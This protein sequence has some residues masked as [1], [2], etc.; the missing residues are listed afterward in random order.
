MK[1]HALKAT[2]MG[3]D[4][5]F[6]S[7]H[8]IPLPVPGARVLRTAFQGGDYIHHSRYSLIFNQDRGFATC[9]AHNIEGD[10]LSRK[11]YKSRSFKFDPL[12]KPNRLQVDKD[13]GYRNNPWDQGHI[14][15]RKSMSWGDPVDAA[16]AERESDHW[17]NIAPQH[18]TLHSNA[19][20]LIEDWMLKRVEGGKH[21]ACVFG[22]PVFTEDD[23]ILQNAPDETPIQIPAGFWKIISIELDGAMRSAAFLLWQRDYDHAEPLPFAPVLEQVRLSTIEVLTGLGFPALRTFD[24]L[25]YDRD[26]N[27]KVA[28]K[29]TKPP[30]RVTLAWD[31]F[32]GITGSNKSDYKSLEQYKSALPAAT[33]ISDEN[34]ILL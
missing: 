31:E 8:T 13:R 1:Q 21:R 10:S 34:D 9:T 18:E 6:I 19:W 5:D 27:L 24:P 16:I 20:G 7:G 15:R 28:N 33:A 23:P 12:I 30:K 25:L 3:Y 4:P 11:Q 14:A 29:R 32:Q 17:S 2:K 22:G 26:Q